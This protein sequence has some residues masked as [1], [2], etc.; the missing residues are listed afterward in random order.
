MVVRVP[1]EGLPGELNQEEP[2]DRARRSSKPEVAPPE[3]EEG[4]QETI[5][6]SL[7]RCRRTERRLT[8][9]LHQLPGSLIPAFVEV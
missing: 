4:D 5:W 1:P 7:N 9:N 2:S 8:D 3:L 6:A